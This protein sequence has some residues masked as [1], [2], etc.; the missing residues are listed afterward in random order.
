MSKNSFEHFA[1]LYHQINQLN[2]MMATIAI[3]LIGFITTFSVNST[4]IYEFNEANNELTEFYDSSYLSSSPN[5]KAFQILDNKCH[6][7]HRK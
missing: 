3:L 4:G 1:S 5:K 2:L 7:C 6:V